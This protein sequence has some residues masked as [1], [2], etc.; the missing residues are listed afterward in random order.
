MSFR[1]PDEI[2]HKMEQLLNL[3]W[4]MLV[5]VPAAL[6]WWRGRRF[7][8]HSRHLFCFSPSLLSSVCL[9]ALLFPV[10]FATDDMQV[11]QGE[12]EESS[13]TERVVKQSASLQSS[14]WANDGGGPA[15]VTQQVSFRPA[16]EACGRVSKYLP[17]LAEQSSAN[18]IDCRVLPCLTSCLCRAVNLRRS[19][20]QC[21]RTGLY[22]AALGGFAT[23]RSLGSPDSKR[24]LRDHGISHAKDYC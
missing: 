9:L 11:M 18:T 4:G 6:I 15:R 8:Q 10:V 12:V 2:Q 13:P 21:P 3:L 14:T 1:R 19:I 20:P 24:C 23:D 7:A 22:R 16:R 17:V 5:V